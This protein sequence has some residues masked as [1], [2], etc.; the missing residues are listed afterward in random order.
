MR[1]GAVDPPRRH[2]RWRAVLAR[3]AALLLT[4]LLGCLLGAWLFHDVQPR[5]L[6]IRTPQGRGLPHLSRKDVLGLLASAG[7]QHAPG[8]IPWIAARDARC[9]VVRLPQPGLLRHY[10]AFPQRDILDIADLARP[11]NAADAADC[12]RL[13]GEI[14]RDQ[15]YPDYRVYTNGPDQQDV[16]YL[17]FHLIALPHVTDHGISEAFRPG[18][19]LP[20]PA[21]TPAPE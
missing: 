2:R 7:I 6:W 1:F 20:R 10:V 5:A 4:L 17:H 21:S 16:R 13:L 14:I 15:G 18:Y 8:A 9:L 3:V 11:E 12:I 19:P